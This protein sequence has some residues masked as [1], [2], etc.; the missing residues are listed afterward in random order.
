MKRSVLTLLALLV[1]AAAAAG[2]PGD[3][4]AAAV[5]RS[6]ADRTSPRGEGKDL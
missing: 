1:V 6:A 2:A 4:S 5:V 3:P